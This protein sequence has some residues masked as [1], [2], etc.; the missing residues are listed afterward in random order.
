MVDSNAL[1]VERIEK[2]WT[3]NAKLYVPHQG[4]EIAFAFPAFGANINQKVGKEILSHNLKVPTGDYTASLLHPVYCNPRNSDEERNVR[5]IMKNNWLWTFNQNLWTDKGVYVIQ[6]LEAKGRSE[7]FDINELEKRLTEKWNNIRVSENGRTRFA[8][9]ESYK[10]G[11]H[12]SDSLSKDGFVIASYGIEGAKKLA[13]VSSKLRNNPV[14][15]GIEIQKG[16]APELRFSALGEDGGR[17][18]VDGSLWD[19]YYWGR[20]F[21]AL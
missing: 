21:G 16:N 1:R 7:E 2:V 19:D 4:E 12:I 15:Y 6:D 5:D 11:E 20:A 17:L 8:P 18:R 13:E 9:K 3:P 10:F 14:T